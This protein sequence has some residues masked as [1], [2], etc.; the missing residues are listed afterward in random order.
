MTACERSRKRIPEVEAIDRAFDLVCGWCRHRCGRI[1]KNMAHAIPVA[2]PRDGAEF[3]RL[4]CES[5]LSLKNK[6]F[7]NV[8]TIAIAITLR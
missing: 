6:G 8:A 4:H 2:H 7:C 5:I 3:F 1:P